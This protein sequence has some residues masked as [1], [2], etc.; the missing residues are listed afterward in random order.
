MTI[1]ENSYCKPQEESEWE[2]I[3]LYNTELYK[4]P[5][6]SFCVEYIKGKKRYLSKPKSSK[7]KIPTQHF[8]D[9]FEDR[10]TSWRL[11]ELGLKCAS[12]MITVRQYEIGLLTIVITDNG[13]VVGIQ[14]HFD[15]FGIKYLDNV[16]TF[17]DLLTLIK[18]L[19]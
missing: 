18:F 10:I 11:E 9:L 13:A 14:S 8:V 3:G 19:K 4:N 17:T 12:P 2:L 7:T 6:Q 15:S 5:I 1:L 16:K